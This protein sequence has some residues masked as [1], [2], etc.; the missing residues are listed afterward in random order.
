MTKT[1]I[2]QTKLAE[3]A[4]LRA[5]ARSLVRERKQLAAG[6]DDAKARTRIRQIWNRRMKIEQRVV[7]IVLR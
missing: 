5:E 7:A 1:T 2:S 4:T 3:L 6:P